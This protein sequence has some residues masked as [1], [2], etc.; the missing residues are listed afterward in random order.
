MDELATAVWAVQM[1]TVTFHPWPV[2]TADN[3]DPDELRL[4]LDPQPGTGL[5]EAVAAA[6]MLREVMAQA[7]LTAYVK[8]SGNRGLHVFAP[9]RPTHEFLDVRHAVI[10]IA[11]ELERRVPDLVTT[12]WWKEQRGSRI[13]ADF[14]QACRDRTLASAYSPRPLPGAPVSMPVTW[15]ELGDVRAGTSPS[16]RSRGCSPGGRTRGRGSATSRARS[17]SRCSGGSGTWTTGWAS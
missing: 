9:I 4:D 2:R 13:F 16:A 17:T 3:D 8:T 11:R 12:A 1:N 15:E 5:A 7:G 6:E 10:A 14:N